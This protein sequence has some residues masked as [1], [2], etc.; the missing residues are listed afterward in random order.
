MHKAILCKFLSKPPKERAAL[1]GII[2]VALIVILVLIL[3]LVNPPA[4]LDL[5]GCPST[6]PLENRI[7]V[8]DRTGEIPESAKRSIRT[9]IEAIVRKAPVGTRFSVFEIDSKYMRGLSSVIFSRCKL[10]DG[11]QASPYNENPELIHRKYVKDFH[12]P[13]MDAL[14][15]VLIGSGQD[16]SPIMEALV[17]VTSV[18]A[19]QI[20]APMTLYLFSD[21]LQNT[22]IY[23]QYGTFRSFQEASALPE[24]NNMIPSLA[25]ADVHL[26]YLLRS[27]RELTM[28]NNAHVQF[29]LDYLY[30][31]NANV[32]LVKKI[33]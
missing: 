12:K 9:N 27:G 4:P 33:R 1:L 32:K 30:M 25:G 14:D 20:P 5:Y 23:S 31:A 2:A 28:Q 17:D 7:F 18:E 29:W 8:I 26:F 15:Q 6:G 11:S 19:F 21:M 3:F 16:R 22:N 13:L 10:R 24:V